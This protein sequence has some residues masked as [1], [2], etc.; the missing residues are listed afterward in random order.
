MPLFRVASDK[1][2]LFFYYYYYLKRAALSTDRKNPIT[3]EREKEK[4]KQKTSYSQ[5]LEWVNNNVRRKEVSA[6]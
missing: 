4:K 2:S 5:S 3:A 1:V 6:K